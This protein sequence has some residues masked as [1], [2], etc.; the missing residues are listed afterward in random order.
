MYLTLL[1]VSAW[2]QFLRRQAANRK[3]TPFL[4]CAITGRCFFFLFSFFF[5]KLR[6][7]NSA[8]SFA[9]GS[10]Q[11]STR[12]C[13]MH[14]RANFTSNDFFTPPRARAWCMMIAGQ[15]SMLLKVTRARTR[16]R[17]TLLTRECRS[18]LSICPGTNGFKRLVVLP[19][20]RTSAS[21]ARRNDS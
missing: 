5:A 7:L 13:A 6:T 1:A 4:F 15:C 8:A 18:L 12:N 21:R 9:H 14:A 11:E 17:V 20:A 3:R 19:R 2:V 16:P 10:V